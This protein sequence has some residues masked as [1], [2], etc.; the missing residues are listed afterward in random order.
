MAQCN[1][2]AVSLWTAR[3]IPVIIICVLGY[4]TYVFVKL[5]CVDY[6]LK[7]NSQAEAHEDRAAAIVILTIYFLL[8]LLV[9]ISY[10]RLLYIVS[11][12]PG[13]IPLGALAE[14]KRRHS[15]HRHGSHQ[16]GQINGS[17]IVVDELEM[18]RANSSSETAVDSQLDPDS[19]GLEDFYTKDI[20]VCE[21]DGRPKW[22]SECSDWKPD[23][24]HHCS[25]VGRCVRKMDHFCPWSV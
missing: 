23:R 15:H 2:K 25:D 24:T 9:V 21:H 12:D 11:T 5:L 17:Q 20:F 8:L 3:V 13:Y 1:P 18:G 4:A 22:C 7:P 6:L 16:R 14:K 10:M 19:P